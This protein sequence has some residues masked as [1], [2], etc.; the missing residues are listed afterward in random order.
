MRMARATTEP[1]QPRVLRLP[2]FRADEPRGLG[3]VVKRATSAVGI[4]PCAPCE[5]RA[6]SLNRRI[7]IT[8]AQ[9]RRP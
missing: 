4:R 5:A 2:G 8:G 7:R 3:D 6:A 1:I 9:R